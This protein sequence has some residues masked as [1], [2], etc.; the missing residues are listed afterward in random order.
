[1]MM[2]GLDRD[3]TQC[4]VT[5]VRG[6]DKLSNFWFIRYLTAIFEHTIFE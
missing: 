1:M 2:D 6:Q 4:S 5:F 3:N